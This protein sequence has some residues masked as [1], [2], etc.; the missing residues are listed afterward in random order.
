MQIFHLG[1]HKTGTTSLQK[2][3]FR[4]SAIPYHGLHSPTW[5]SSKS[6]W[7]DF[8]M[9][10][11][12]PPL[13]RNQ[14]FVFS[15]EP[16]LLR[17]GGLSG[18]DQIT[19][20]ITQNF[21]DPTILISIREPSALLVSA[22]FHS[23]KLRRAALGFHGGKHAYD[24]SLRFISFKDWWNLLE[25]NRN[26]SLAGLLDYPSLKQA[27]ERRISSQRVVFLKL[28]DLA[29]NNP[30]YRE[31]L[32]QLGFEDSLVDSFISA[33]PENTGSTRKLQRERPKLSRLGRQLTK[34][35]LSHSI[36]K[37][38]ASTGL[39][40]PAE[41]ILYGGAATAKSQIDVELLSEIRER[42]RSGFELLD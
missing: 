34:I 1:L 8:F 41:K 25:A 12:R 23:L 30:V 7:M 28:E 21:S 6:D 9:E 33:P 36:E 27:F 29:S 22:Y 2:H 35:G 37:I 4:K 24:H 16:T 10:S 3:L 14:S 11:G 32:L 42:Y 5:E 26:I 38:L 40:R 15:C 17:C 39:L 19:S 18:I 13:S 20:K 31:K